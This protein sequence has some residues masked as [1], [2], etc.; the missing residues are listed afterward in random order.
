MLKSLAPEVLDG[1]PYSKAVDYWS[2]GIVLYQ[3]LIGKPPFEFNGDFAKLLHAI[4]SQKVL[5]PTELISENA[6][7]FLEG[8]SANYHQL[9]ILFV[10]AAEQRS[11][12]TIR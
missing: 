12:K 3:L 9:L 6:I 8:V 10:L 7:L 5:Y 11:S 1:S 4:Q 2:L